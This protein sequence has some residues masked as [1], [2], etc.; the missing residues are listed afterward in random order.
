MEQRRE[1]RARREEM[2]MAGLGGT[3]NQGKTKERQVKIVLHFTEEGGGDAQKEYMLC[4]A[5]MSRLSRFIAAALSSNMREGE[6]GVVHLK[7]VNPDVFSA[8]IS[9]VGDP[10]MARGMKV[11]DVIQVADFY[12]RFEF[13]T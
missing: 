10:V 13:T 11:E 3:S 6:T 8:A 2:V 5:A 12:N 1:K 7:D 9:F 4:A